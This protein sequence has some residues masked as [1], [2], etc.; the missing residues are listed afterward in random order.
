MFIGDVEISES[1]EVSA[2]ACMICYQ[3]QQ[4][5]SLEKPEFR[6]RK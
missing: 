5:R 1:N 6:H 4:E 3:G 2:G